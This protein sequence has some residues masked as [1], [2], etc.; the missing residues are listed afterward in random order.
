MSLDEIKTAF[1]QPAGKIIKIILAVIFSCI[2]V[3][4]CFFAIV[5]NSDAPTEPA[6]RAAPTIDFNDSILTG[7]A[8]TLAA[9]PTFTPFP[10][11]TPPPLQPTLT[12]QPSPTD[13]IY[14]PPTSGP[15][16][17]V[18]PCIRNQPQTAL[19]TD[20]VDGDTIKVLLDG[21]VYP[22]RYLGIDTPESTTQHEYYGKEAS[23]KNAELVGGKQV[24][25]Y[26]DI[27]ETDKYN[28][29][30]RYIFVGDT[31]INYEL[32]KQGFANAKRYP[33][34]TACAELFEQA[35][36]TA[37][38]A[39]LGMWANVPQELLATPTIPPSA[40]GGTGGG[41]IITS[42]NKS[43]EYVDIQNTSSSQ[44]N[45][46]GWKLVSEKGNQSCTLNGT[47]NPNDTLRIFAASG[48]AGFN[49]N[50]S[51][52]IWNNS[53]PDPAVLYNAQGVEVDRK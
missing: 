39:L 19:V 26:T 53:E 37:K 20:V 42:V 8:E 29:L 15:Q 36:A 13:F 24:T 40:G 52:A 23:A 49:C 27:S 5:A 34:D 21:N 41:V 28:R 6:Q 50:F 35:E 30:L 43:A 18:P 45:L 10:T 38:T 2:L 7:V 16:G 1:Q 31:F 3:C 4:C 12:L 44:V 25:I 47:I 32:V 9:I 14:S 11:Y 33:P 48:Q 22:V 46:A 51:K 17:N